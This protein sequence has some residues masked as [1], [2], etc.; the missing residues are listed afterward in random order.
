MGECSFWYRPTRVVPDQR[1]LNG[2]CCCCCMAAK[3]SWRRY[4]TKLRH[5]HPMYPV[6]VKY[7]KVGFRLMSVVNEWDD[8]G[9][10]EG[11]VRSSRTDSDVSLTRILELLEWSRW[12]IKLWDSLMSPHSSVQAT[13]Q[14]Q[15]QW[16]GPV[17]EQALHY[18]TAYIY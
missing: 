1:P 13:D 5:C 11:S 16:A 12:C 2:R 14:S 6:S 18:N 7:L 10:C 3:T 4:A 8:S 15:H 9:S 17:V